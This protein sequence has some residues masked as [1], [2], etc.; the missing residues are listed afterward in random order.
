MTFPPAMRAPVAPHSQHLAHSFLTNIYSG[1]VEYSTIVVLVCISLIACDVEHF[2]QMFI[3][4]LFFFFV[5][6]VHSLFSNRLF[7]SLLLR[8]E[9]SLYLWCILCWC[10]LQKISSS[11]IRLHSLALS[12]LHF[13]KV[14]CTSI[15][16]WT[17]YGCIWKVTTSKVALD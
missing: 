4:H 3:C 1:A 14:Q 6:V 8:H 7:I 13:N 10:V 11:L 15:L 16:M 9:S 12:S 2:F 5:C 17:L